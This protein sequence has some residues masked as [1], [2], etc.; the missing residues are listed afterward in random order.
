MQQ[1]SV[2]LTFAIALCLQDAHGACFTITDQTNKTIYQSNTSPI[3]LSKSIS[4]EMARHYPGSHLVTSIYDCNRNGPSDDDD[5]EAWNLLSELKYSSGASRYNRSRG[6]L[7]NG[8]Q[9]TGGQ[10]SGNNRNA[11]TDVSV[12]S[13][14]RGGRTVQGY[15]RAAPGRGR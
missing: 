15:T 4:E 11:G 9:S 10:L 14:Q 7:S 1:I 13:Y 3:D 5:S 2:L 6:S 8:G 12:R